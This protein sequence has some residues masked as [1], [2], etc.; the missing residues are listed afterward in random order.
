MWRMAVRLRRIVHQSTPRG[1]ALGDAFA[2][3]TANVN[4][5]TL[6]YVL[7]GSGPAFILLHGFPQDWSVRSVWQEAVLSACPT[8]ENSSCSIEHSA[9]EDF[10][11]DDA[12]SAVHWMVREKTTTASFRTHDRWPFARRR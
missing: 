12:R 5:T 10:S 3:R 2:S 7:A 9:P 1:R 8:K 4:G 6:H 11:G